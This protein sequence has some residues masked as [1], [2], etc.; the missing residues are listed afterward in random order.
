LS[1]FYLKRCK[2]PHSYCKS[3][4]RYCENVADNVCFGHERKASVKTLQD[5]NVTALSTGY[6]K[7]YALYTVGVIDS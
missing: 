7:A 3:Q 5:K 6:E 4:P 1:D 2:L